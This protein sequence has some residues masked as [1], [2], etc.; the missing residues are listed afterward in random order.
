MIQITRRQIEDG[1]RACREDAYSDAVTVDKRFAES[2]LRQLH[3]L[4]L[5]ASVEGWETPEA[6]PHGYARDKTAEGQ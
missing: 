6:L 4:Y 5:A 3:A 2:V 1:I